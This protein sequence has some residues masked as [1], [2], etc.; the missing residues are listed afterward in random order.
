MFWSFNRKSNTVIPS[1]TVQI[2]T[3]VAPQDEDG[4]LKEYPSFTAKV[5]DQIDKGK[6][7]WSYQKIGVFQQDA[8]GQDPYLIGEYIRNYHAFSETFAVTR[9]GDK[10]Y[11]LYSPHY[12]GTR[13]LEITPGVGI[14]D[15]GGEEKDSDGFCP[16]E[17]Y[18]PTIRQHVSEDDYS[19][20]DWK[21][22]LEKF[23]P[24]ARIGDISSK[25]SGR[26]IIYYED[27]T[28]V[29]AYT[30]KINDAGTSYERD[31]YRWVW[32]PKKDYAYGSVILPPKHAFVAGC[33]WGD[34]TSWKIQYFNISRI[35]EGIIVREERFGYISLPTH[36][37][38][39][40][41]IDT[42]YLDDT[43]GR[44]K[45]AIEVSF[46]INGG[47]LIDWDGLSEQIKKGNPFLKKQKLAIDDW[48]NKSKDVDED[49]KRRWA[50]PEGDAIRKLVAEIGGE[51]R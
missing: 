43:D 36:L 18:I 12:T 24:G 40:D 47:G 15:I 46:D 26:K 48:R 37:S 50:G 28:R 9:K 41:A 51:I 2:P 34:D 16:V 33:Y 22:L 10:Y 29:R 13:V 6:G 42:E 7:C 11:A 4:Y 19:E 32:G 25:M 14:K 8:Q 31:E 1:V 49:L 39:K 5:I 27:G 21:N 3:P 30:G 44:F 23:P 20:N 35:D 45:I 38:L 17:L